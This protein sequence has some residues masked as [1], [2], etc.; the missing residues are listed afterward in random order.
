MML[1]CGHELLTPVMSPTDVEKLY[2]ET[3]LVDRAVIDLS[4]ENAMT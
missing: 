4:W 2:E 3:P 1:I